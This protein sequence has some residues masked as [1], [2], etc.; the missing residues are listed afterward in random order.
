MSS[1]RVNAGTNNSSELLRLAKEE[2]GNLTKAEERLF[3]EVANGEIADYR[4][5]K[6]KEDNDPKN[7]G[8]WGNERVIRSKC[9]EWLCTDKEALELVTHKGIQVIG[10]RIDGEIGLRFVKIEFPLVFVECAI[11]NGIKLQHAEIKMLSLQGTHTGLIRA[12]GLEVKGSILLL[13]VKNLGGVFLVGATIGGELSCK[14]GEFINRNGPAL[15]CNSAK[16]SQ[17]IHLNEGFKAE[18][19]VDLGSATIGGQ[20]ECS[21]GE[22]INPKGTALNG[23]ALKVTRSVLLRNGFKAKGEVNLRGAD[24]EGQLSCIG[25]K[26]INPNGM[27]FIGDSV[28][29]EESILLANGFKAEGEVRLTGATIGVQLGCKNAQFINPDGNAIIA[30]EL[31][32]VGNVFLSEGFKAKGKVRLHSTTIG[33]DLI[34][35]GG[36]FINPKGEAIDGDSL[37]VGRNVFLRNGFKAE[38]EVYL[39]GAKIGGQ[40]VCTGGQF[41]NPNGKAINADSIIV[42]KHVFL[43]NHFEAEGKIDFVGAV[44]GGIFLWHKVEFPERITLDLRSANIGTLHDE[45]KSWPNNGKLFLNGLTYSEIYDKSPKDAKT[46]IEWIRRQYDPENK[47][48]LQFRPQPYEQLAEVLKKSGNE[49]DAKEVLIAKNKDRLKWGP[50][51]TFSELWWYRIFGPLIGYGHK[52]LRSLK[53]IAGCI[54]LGWILFGYGHRNNYI[55]SISNDSPKFNSIVYS[56]DTFVPLIDLQ[57]AKYWLPKAKYGPEL[58]HFKS[59]VIRVGSIFRLCHWMLIAFGWILTTLFVVGL[60][61]LVKT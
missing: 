31:K 32:V 29:V 39:V 43:F 24:I 57:Q 23:D 15:N 37:T 20:L 30:D 13:N 50:K 26:F 16:V 3:K 28:K 36:Q 12:D 38:G 17:N 6:K 14:G 60:T 25:G 34:C 4:D 10:M 44:I 61:G 5:K 21:G 40:L 33:G 19:K 56:I 27:A 45:P 58:F 59:Y 7:A 55:R 9:V 51:L 53:Y 52:P 49:D 2:F 8:K 48:D 11:L 47:K 46:R 41:I 54:V 18:G 35:D 42:D 22:F 1:D